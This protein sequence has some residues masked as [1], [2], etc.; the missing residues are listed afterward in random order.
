MKSIV[1]FVI[2]LLIICTTASQ[3]SDRPTEFFQN[4]MKLG[5]AFDPA[6]VNLTLIKH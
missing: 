6:V 5:E 4:Y 3:A 1:N 2:A